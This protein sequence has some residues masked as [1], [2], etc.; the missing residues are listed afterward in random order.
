M[1]IYECYR[2]RRA[3]AGRKRGYMRLRRAR[4]GSK[5]WMRRARETRHVVLDVIGSEIS[6]WEGKEDEDGGE[7]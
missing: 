1:T 5:T 3:G 6:A 7:A 2:D 4:E